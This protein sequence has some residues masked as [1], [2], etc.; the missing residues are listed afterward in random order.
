M[1]DD[2]SSAAEDPETPSGSEATTTRLPGSADP[3]EQP[4]QRVTPR[5][6]AARVPIPP[7]DV[8]PV[9]E[10]APPEWEPEWESEREPEWKQEKPPPEPEPTGSQSAVQPVVLTL[11]VVVLL[12]MFGTGLWLTFHRSSASPV[13]VPALPPIASASPTPA[14][15]STAADTDT[16]TQDA[17]PTEAPT[18]T[19]V[20][21]TAPATPTQAPTPSPSSPALVAVP[22][23]LVGSP[24]EEAERKLTAVGLTYWPTDLPRGSVVVSTT[25][26][27]GAMV[28]PGS[29]VVLVVGPSSASP[30]AKPPGLGVTA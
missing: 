27:S 22:K 20:P 2:R 25:P 4:T 14:D 28:P 13:P 11:I 6:W 3:G 7:D 30:S 19:Q 10:P 29:Q 15:V 12:A 24:V 5:I 9:P 21:T 16:P 17:T 26:E 18:P 23:G 1:A 8:A